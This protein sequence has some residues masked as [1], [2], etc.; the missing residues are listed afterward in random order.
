MSVGLHRYTETES[1]PNTGVELAAETRIDA[2]RET[3]AALELQDDGEMPFPKKGIEGIRQADETLKQAGAVG[4]LIGGLAYDLYSTPKSHLDT[5]K[6]ANHKDVDVII[7][8]T[9][10]FLPK[11]R[12]QDGIDWWA[13]DEVIN[14]ITSPGEYL[15]GGRGDVGKITL[16]FLISSIDHTDLEPGLHIPD[17]AFLRTIKKIELESALVKQGA[18]AEDSEKIGLL[19]D[20]DMKADTLID[21]LDPEDEEAMCKTGYHE[22]KKQID[23]LMAELPDVYEWL[24]PLMSITR[25]HRSS[26][27]IPFA[28]HESIFNNANH[29]DDTVHEVASLAVG[30]IVKV[31]G[32]EDISWL[33]DLPKISLTAKHKTS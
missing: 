11:K 33:T 2:T 14:G 26:P 1:R 24:W 15:S 6:L 21:G 19:F 31:D 22:I 12:W 8:G 10:A 4:V 25:S 17:I 28:A 27:N 29:Q 9:D 16:D 30:S 32:Q 3:V 13:Y 5:D 23:A 20:L 18:S 7:L